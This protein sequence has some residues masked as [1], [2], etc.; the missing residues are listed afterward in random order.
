MSNAI[1]LPIHILFERLEK[2]EKGEKPTFSFTNLVAID[3]LGHTTIMIS[4][5]QQQDRE[6]E[7]TGVSFFFMFVDA[8]ICYY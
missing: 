2:L 1:S 4:V 5:V 7:I 6:T 3:K 8:F